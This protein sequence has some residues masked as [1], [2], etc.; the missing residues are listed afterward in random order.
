MAKITVTVPDE[1]LEFFKAGATRTGLSFSPYL[2][3]AAKIG[4]LWED[5][6]RPRAHDDAAELA[7]AQELAAL[8]AAADVEN[9][10]LP[11]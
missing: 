10:G 2:V 1:D 6:H 7:R 9:G 4:A 3:R 11:D 5:T 8:E